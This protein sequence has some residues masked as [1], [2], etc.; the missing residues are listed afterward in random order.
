MFLW[1]ILNCHVKETCHTENTQIGLKL[2]RKLGY[3]TSEKERER[4]RE[5][6]PIR[7]G[8]GSVKVTDVIRH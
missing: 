4:E 8:V 7:P 2:I 6:D 1:V 5:R 3:V